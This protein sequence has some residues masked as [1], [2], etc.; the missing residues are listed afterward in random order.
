MAVL[1]VLACGEEQPPAP[2]AFSTR[3]LVIA[4][5]DE[6]QDGT[7]LLTLIDVR[8]GQKVAQLTSG[9][10]TWALQRHSTGEL[11]VSDLGGPNFQG[12][13]LVFDL[14]GPDAPKWTIPMPDRTVST[15]WAQA[16]SL[17]EDERYLLRGAIS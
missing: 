1:A 8:T 12:R 3:D 4:L 10:Q 9:Y 16:M 2:Q 11:L 14:R 17:S 5:D 13:L 6:Y 15:V 7:A